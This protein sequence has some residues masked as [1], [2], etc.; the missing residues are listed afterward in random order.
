MLTNIKN[1][2][3]RL[4]QFGR[5]CLGGLIG[6]FAGG[7]MPLAQWLL[8]AMDRIQER[9]RNNQSRWPVLIDIAE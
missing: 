9:K 3:S 4:W 8:N 1:S 5:A 6:I 7:T 2:Q